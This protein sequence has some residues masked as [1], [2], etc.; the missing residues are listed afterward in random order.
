MFGV[1]LD[2]IDTGIDQDPPQPGLKGLIGL[3]LANVGKYF[4][5][6]I[7]E[8]LHCIGL[9]TGVA[10]AYAHRVTV[11]VAVQLG[12]TLPVVFLTAIDDKFQK[13]FDL[14]Q[15]QPIFY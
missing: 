3:E 10:N 11:K 14:G 4:H 2:V 1:A 6:P 7:I 9:V 15:C 8:H 13:L 12:L 5:E